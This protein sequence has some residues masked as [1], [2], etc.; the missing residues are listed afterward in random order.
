MLG[1]GNPADAL[2]RLENRQHRTVDMRFVTIAKSDAYDDSAGQ[3][4]YGRGNPFLRVVSETGLYSLLMRS[5]KSAPKP[6]RDWVTEESLPSVR[7]G[8]TDI[9]TAVR[10][11]LRLP[12]R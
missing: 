10:R 9:R 8:D 7:R 11:V 3:K 2:K 1:R 6:F 12:G 4:V 5:N